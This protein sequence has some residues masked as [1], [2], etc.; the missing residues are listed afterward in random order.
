MTV[1]ISLGLVGESQPVQIKVA[2]E[3][4]RIVET[5]SAY[6]VASFC[7]ALF[8]L[9]LLCLR[10]EGVFA[11]FLGYLEERARLEAAKEGRR[12]EI[13]R[14]VE[15]REQMTLPGVIRKEE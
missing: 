12:I 2:D 7:A 13:L 10:K 14:M 9:L 8:I 4:Q 3:F 6:P 5:M 15:E 11:R 1:T